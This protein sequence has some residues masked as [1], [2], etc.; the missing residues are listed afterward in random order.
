MEFYCNAVYGRQHQ[1]TSYTRQCFKFTIWAIT[2][3][4]YWYFH[5]VSFEGNSLNSNCSIFLREMEVLVLRSTSKL[6]RR[7][8]NKVKVKFDS[9]PL[10]L[11]SATPGLMRQFELYA[12]ITPTYSCIHIR[13][14][15]HCLPQPPQCSLPAAD[16][17]E[18]SGSRSDWL[19]ESTTCEASGRLWLFT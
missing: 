13:C 15:M 17:L 16:L 3:D 10:W 11:R 12:I 9:H 1:E 5:Y 4:R 19:N 6:K 7:C 14:C 2:W 18:R 8:N